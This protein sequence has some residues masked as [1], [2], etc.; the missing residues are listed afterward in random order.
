MTPSGVPYAIL[1]HQNPRIPDVK[2]RS[3][4]DGDASTRVTET[5]SARA[6]AASLFTGSPRGSAVHGD[7]SRKRLW[8]SVSLTLS[9]GVAAVMMAAGAVA[10]A[11]VR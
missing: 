1:A 4:G 8:S 6:C 9:Y 3:N 7:S 11:R 2:S 5:R 10:L